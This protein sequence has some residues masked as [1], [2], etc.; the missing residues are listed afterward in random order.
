MQAA[1]IFPPFG[2]TVGKEFALTDP[3]FIISF[4]AFVLFVVLLAETY[5]FWGKSLEFEK[6]SNSDLEMDPIDEA[7]ATE[8]STD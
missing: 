2:L 1:F 8:A 5:T 6:K 7:K 4:L 3:G